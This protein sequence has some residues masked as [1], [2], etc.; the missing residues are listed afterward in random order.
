MDRSKVL[1]TGSFVK[2]APSL[3]IYTPLLLVVIYVFNRDF[4]N[5]T[6]NTIL[7]SAILINAVLA[8]SWIFVR[9]KKSKGPDVTIGS[10]DVVTKEDGTMLFSLELKME[11]EDLAKMNVVSFKV[12]NL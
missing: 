3:L 9:T 11:P 4:D 8:L 5:N 12:R 7:G 6:L 1:R 10:I 2:T